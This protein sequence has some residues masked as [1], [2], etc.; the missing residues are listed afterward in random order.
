MK[1]LFSDMDEGFLCCYSLKE[2]WSPVGMIGYEKVRL[3]NRDFTEDFMHIHKNKLFLLIAMLGAIICFIGDNLLGCFMPSKLFGNSIFFPA[4]S[5]DWANANPLRFAIGGLCGVVALLMM[6]CGFYSIYKIMKCK[7]LKCA[8]IFLISSFDFTSVGT[9]YHCVFAMTAFVYNRLINEGISIAQSISEELFY[10]FIGVSAFAA[11]G[12]GLLSII[13][14]WATY[15][16]ICDSKYMAFINPLIIMLIC[17]L[18]SK[19]LPSTNYINGIFGW[20]QQS[21]GLFFTFL[22][23]YMRFESCNIMEQSQK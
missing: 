3:S 14:F 15:K 8:N 5:F 1:V 16:K 22:I 13:L 6:S 17:V 9:L 7:K 19:I 21:I 4:F 12:F 2:S 11:V 20:G 10:T 18:L 23:Y